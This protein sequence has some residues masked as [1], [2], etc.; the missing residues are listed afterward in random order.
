MLCLYPAITADLSAVRVAVQ[1]L[2]LHWWAMDQWSWI[3]SVAATDYSVAAACGGNK[4]HA[5]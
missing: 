5:A 4:V 2:A 1:L 3:F